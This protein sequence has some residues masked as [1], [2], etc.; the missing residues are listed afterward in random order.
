MKKLL[1]FICLFALTCS[2]LTVPVAAQTSGDYDTDL[3]ST[4]FFKQNRERVRAALPENGIALFF[5][6]DPKT[7]NNDMEYL[8]RQSN[9]LYY[10]TGHIEP[11][12]MLLI[13]KSPLSIRGYGISEILVVQP[14]NPRAETWTGRRL[15][16]AGAMEQLGVQ[17]AITTDS[18]EPVSAKILSFLADSVLKRNSI[19]SV[20]L[21][22]PRSDF[23]YSAADGDFAKLLIDVKQ[24]MESKKIPVNNISPLLGQMRQ[25]KQPEE[26]KLM[27][28]ASDVTV[29][30]HRE[31][32][33]SC[34]PG[35]Y[36]YEVAAVGEYVFRKG[37]CEY[38]S[39]PSIVGAGENSVILHY[40]S[41]RKRINDGEL[42][43][44]DMAGEYHGYAC[45]VTRTI[46]ANGKFSPEQKLIYNLVLAA[47]DSAIAQCRAG[48]SF[49]APHQK[50]SEI[51]ADGLVKLGLIQNK[52]EFRRYFM[53]GSSHSVGL[54]VHD[55]NMAILQAGQV[56]TVEPGIYIAAG[57]PCDKKWWNIG[58]RIEDMIVITENGSRMLSG[59]LER[60]TD[61]IEKLMK[62]K[63]VGNVNTGVRKIQE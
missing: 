21:A 4:E 28:R 9:A 13:A 20:S 49:I 40:V 38:T 51:I 41:T 62:E 15:G 27:E 47:Q 11:E 17:L 37:G 14:R 29:A 30:A 18:L 7:R 36:E 26:L 32:I 43:L 39:Y 57:S 6:N 12:S 24:L 23:N 19:S 48:N 58:V 22:L 50:A 34:E 31:A 35:M 60:K 59:T 53:H 61:D 25:I 10:L 42:L 56:F 44:M 45:D 1:G 63:G 55:P 5:S 46:P 8:F 16:T 3:L 2:A 33:K 52:N 54:D